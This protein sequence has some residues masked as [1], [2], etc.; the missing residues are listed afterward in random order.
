MSRS[1][2]FDLDGSIGRRL[3]RGTDS[4]AL[5]GRCLFVRDPPTSTVQWIAPPRL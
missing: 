3:H 1:R 2:N 5:L 4:A